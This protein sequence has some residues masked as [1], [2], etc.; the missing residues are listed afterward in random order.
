MQEI[1]RTLGRL[2]FPHGPGF[3]GVLIHVTCEPLIA[4][5]KLPSNMV[6]EEGRSW[7]CGAKVAC[8]STL[9]AFLLGA[10]FRVRNVLR[11]RPCVLRTF[12]VFFGLKPRPQKAEKEET[13]EGPTPGAGAADTGIL[14]QRLSGNIP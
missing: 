2:G 4:E 7:A 1:L 8:E 3:I 12:T 6:A 9:S 13:K 10:L 5:V 11:F 14:T